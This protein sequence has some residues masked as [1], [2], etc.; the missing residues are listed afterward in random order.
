M[1]TTSIKVNM[2]TGEMAWNKREIGNAPKKESNIIQIN[3]IP[4]NTVFFTLSK[5]QAITF[6]LVVTAG[7]AGFILLKPMMLPLFSA[8]Q[9]LPYQPPSTPL[10]HLIPNTTA[11]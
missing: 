11:L 9:T 7:I 4:S 10:F 6:G 3:S 5:K 1:S 2:M 8:L